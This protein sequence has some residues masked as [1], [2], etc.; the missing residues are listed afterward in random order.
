MSSPVNSQVTVA[1]GTS[2]PA[3]AIQRGIP[4]V[5]TPASAQHNAVIQSAQQTARQ[6]PPGFPTPALFHTTPGF[7]TPANQPISQRR[8]PNTVPDTTEQAAD[9]QQ[10]IDLTNQAPAANNN[11]NNSNN[12]NNDPDNTLEVGQG[13]G[14]ELE[15]QYRLFINKDNTNDNQ[16]QR[17]VADKIITAYAFLETHP[18]TAAI[19]NRNKVSYNIGTTWLNELTEH[20][21]IIK[22]LMAEDHDTTTKRI[23]ALFLDQF[24][25]QMA[26]LQAITL[27]KWI[28]P[29]RRTS[30]ETS[31][32]VYTEATSKLKNSQITL[33]YTADAPA[34][35]PLFLQLLP[36]K[37]VLRYTN[38]LTKV[39]ASRSQKV[40]DF[41][42][43][44]IEP[45][46]EAKTF[47]QHAMTRLDNQ[48]APT[49]QTGR[50]IL[51]FTAK[52]ACM[53]IGPYTPSSA[54]NIQKIL[55]YTKDT[56]RMKGAALTHAKMLDLYKTG[57]CH[58]SI[59]ENFIDGLTATLGSLITGITRYSQSPSRS[60]PDNRSTITSKPTTTSHAH[61]T[62]STHHPD[63]WLSTTPQPP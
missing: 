24:E 22:D 17:Q 56:D 49:S 45:T 1:P 16:C 38:K 4:A 8:M 12:D 62:D 32:V 44:C 20:Y 3:P 5:E 34:G 52:W 58:E 6:P 55:G 47:A 30:S 51:T 28:L 18:S 11:V 13:L 36:N 53:P 27:R 35:C 43:T 39:L 37:I 2:Q 40:Y 41:V 15:Q 26:E 57:Q 25:K 29:I 14:G 33:N 31:S 42:A 54:D 63:T 50:D 9:N 46:Q 7:Q 60:Q 48:F 23:I 19:Q 21:S 61:P 10:A 59:T